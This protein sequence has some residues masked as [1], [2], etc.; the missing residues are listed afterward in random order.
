MAL[1]TEPPSVNPGQPSIQ[2]SSSRLRLQVRDAL[3]AGEAGSSLNPEE[4]NH[5]NHTVDS[6]FEARL[7]ARF[8]CDCSSSWC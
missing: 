8:G 3:Y 2:G 1:M 5:S 4:V 7:P 6:A